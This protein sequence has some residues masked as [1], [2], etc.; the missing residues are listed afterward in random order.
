MN[1]MSIDFDAR[2]AG[3]TAAVA[4]HDKAVSIQP[5]F[6]EVAETVILAHLRANG[7]TAGEVL[8]DIAVAHGARPHDQRAFGAVFS[9]MSRRG[10]IRTVGFC[11]REK[12]HGTAGGRIWGLTT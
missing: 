6:S 2:Q 12:G 4:C 10:L 7:D 8:T 3:E 5:T 11:M 9:R 1:Q